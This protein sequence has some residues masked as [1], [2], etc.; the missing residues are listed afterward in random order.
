[1]VRSLGQKLG[2]RQ[3]VLLSRRLGQLSMPRRIFVWVF[4]AAGL[5]PPDRCP[6]VSFWEGKP[7]KLGTL[8]LTSLLEDLVVYVCFVTGFAPRNLLGF[9]FQ[10]PAFLKFHR[11]PKGVCLCCGCSLGP[12]ENGLWHSCS[13]KQGRH[14]HIQETRL[15]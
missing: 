6:S 7:P 12:P 14:T 2:D 4:R 15:E 8:I 5:G 9:V 3:L 1:M 10:A 13:Q 11:R